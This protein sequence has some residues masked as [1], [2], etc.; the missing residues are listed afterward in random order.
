M[1]KI[2][3]FTVFSGF[4]GLSLYFT[5]VI[6]G[7]IPSSSLHTVIHESDLLWIPRLPG[8]SNQV[9][10]PGACGQYNGEWWHRIQCPRPPSLEDRE[11]DWFWYPEKWRRWT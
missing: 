4:F 11:E 6:F 9:I 10:P 8:S 3:L 5:S 2:V 7:V 1:I